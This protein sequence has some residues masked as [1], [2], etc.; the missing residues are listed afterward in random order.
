MAPA[1]VRL[2]VLTAAAQGNK[3]VNQYVILRKLGGGSYGKVKL[4]MNSDDN[5]L[6]AL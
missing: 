1:W 4:A 5:E 6:Y 2:A 3:L